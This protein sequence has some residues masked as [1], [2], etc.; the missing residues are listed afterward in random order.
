[1]LFTMLLIIAG[2]GMLI[3]GRPFGLDLIIFGVVQH[4]LFG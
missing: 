3:A 2:V 4:F 1:M